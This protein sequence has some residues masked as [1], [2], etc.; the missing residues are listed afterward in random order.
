VDGPANKPTERN[1]GV[2]GVSGAQSA[3]MFDA[4][5][6]LVGGAPN[7]TL[8]NA[9]QACV[10]AY[11][12]IPTNISQIVGVRWAWGATTVT[13]FH[14]IVPP[15]SKQYAFG[16]CRTSCPGCGG[17]DSAYA[18]AQSNHAGGVNVLF[19]DGSVKFIKDSIAWSTWMGLGTKSNGEVIDAASY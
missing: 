6:L 15:N 10:T 8:V 13:L 17:D 12:G 2:T 18:N 3:D 1:H 11:Q 14:T 9:L 4:S 16:S 5:T 19:A 7:A